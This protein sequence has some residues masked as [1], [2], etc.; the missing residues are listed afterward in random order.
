MIFETINYLDY[1]INQIMFFIQ[2]PFL[3]SIMKSITN[4]GDELVL[5]ILSFLLLLFLLY[6]KKYNYLF[7]LAFGMA[8][9]FILVWLLKNIIQ[10]PRP[11]NSLIE[12]SGYSLPSG[13]ATMS[14]IFFSLLIYFFKDEIKNKILKIIVISMGILLMVLIGFSRIYLHAHW[15]SDV[16]A[17]Y[18]LG[19]LLVFITLKLR[20]R[21]FKLQ[22]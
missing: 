7:S 21:I 3:V 17:G 10:R 8:S 16:F 15:I 12:V 18:C 1:S 11:P 14:L 9:G 20:K 2:H 22:S 13:H 19:I 4:I 6:K 5:I